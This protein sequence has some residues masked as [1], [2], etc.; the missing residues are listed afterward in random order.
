MV[1][2]DPRDVDT[3]MLEQVAAADGLSPAD[4]LKQCGANSPIGRVTEASEAVALALFM[5]SEA[6]AQIAGVALPI[7]GGNTA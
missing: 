7:D 5:A 1:A 2:I 4:A 6:A 3:P